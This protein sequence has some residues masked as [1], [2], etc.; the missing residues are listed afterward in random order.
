MFADETGTGEGEKTSRVGSERVEG[1]TGRQDDSA[2]GV[3]VSTQQEGGGA[4]DGPQQ[5]GYS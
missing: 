1:A 3:S 5:V 4:A 2:G